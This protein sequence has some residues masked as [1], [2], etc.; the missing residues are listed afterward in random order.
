M[1]LK[2][3]N[4]L[5]D[6]GD[7]ES[8]LAHLARLAESPADAPDAFGHRAY[9]YRAMG[10]YEEALADYD[11]L[12]ERSPDNLE[13]ASYRGEMLLRIGRDQEGIEAL[14]DVLGRNPLQPE[15]VE[16]IAEYQARRSSIR[17]HP[18]RLVPSAL[19]TPPV[20]P[21]IE[22]LEADPESYPGSVFPEIGRILYDLVRL[23]RPRVALETGS[24]K[25][26]STVTTAQAMKDNGGG[27]LH[28]F[29]LFQKHPGY[30][31]PVLGP[32]ED[33]TR[34]VRG[35]LEHAG[36]AGYV[37]L[38][39]G[40]SSLRIRK[41]LSLHAGK[42]DFAFIDGDHT[43]KGCLKDWSAVDELLAPG[44]LVLLHDTEPDLC[45]WLGPRYLLEKLGRGSETGYH[46]VNLP[47]PEGFGLALIQKKRAETWKTVRP[48]LVDLA[49][50][51][52][53]LRKHG[54]V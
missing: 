43:I 8:A 54:W 29:D 47:S 51:R 32:C 22:R 25:G 49:V 5:I 20:N 26:Y 33:G 3:A 39:K 17:K 18:R 35:H 53:H 4:D 40:D 12:L 15:P 34:I 41:D 10:R 6:A 24:F 52:F 14:L 7:Y 2:H 42:I 45:G 21:V 9:L 50:E 48:S 16:M 44:A 1:T 13:A 36:L 11:A 37:T 31:S 23:V 30:V 28:A 38:H 19:Q 46:W 27:H